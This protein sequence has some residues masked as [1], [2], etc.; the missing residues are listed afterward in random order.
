[1]TDSDESPAVDGSVTT[2]AAA[3]AS[4]A[5]ESVAGAAAGDPAPE[6]APDPELDGPSVS[7]ATVD[8]E[9]AGGRDVVVPLALY[10]RITVFS[11]LF[12]VV[13]VLAGFIL[14]DMAT[15]RASR[16][17]SEVNVVLAVAGLLSIGAGA[18]V[19]AF[20]TRFRTSGM[21]NPKDGEG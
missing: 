13:A 2:D 18:A 10:K 6:H 15:G 11:T 12:A 9:G 5:D 19:Y 1:M 14:L 8:P 20:S 17:L 21:G 3:D 16:D 4:A 7:D